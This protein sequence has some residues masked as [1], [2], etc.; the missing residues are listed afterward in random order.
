M[1][2]DH[3]FDDLSEL[4][5][6]IYLYAATV[7]ADGK[8][9]EIETREFTNQLKLILGTSSGNVKNRD[10]DLSDFIKRLYRGGKKNPLMLDRQQVEYLAG[11]IDS[12]ELRI[13]IMNAIFEIA[14]SDDNYHESEREIVTILRDCW[15]V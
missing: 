15:G 6:A 4:E 2:R 11:V 12:D 10:A 3:E 9:H 5:A 8:V 14:Y 1:T 13:Q 7:L